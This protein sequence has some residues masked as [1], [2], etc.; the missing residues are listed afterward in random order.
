MDGGA[1]RAAVHG[2]A[3]GRTWLSNFTFTFHFHALEKEMATHSSVRAWRISGTGEPGGAAVYE[4]AQSRTRLKWL[5]SS[6]SIWKDP[7]VGRDWGR[8][9]KG[10]TEWAGWVASPTR[11]TWLWVNSGSWWC[12]GCW[13]SWGRK[14]SDTTEQLNWTELCIPLGLLLSPCFLSISFLRYF[15]DSGTVDHV[16]LSCVLFHSSYP[17]S[18]LFWSLLRGWLLNIDS[19]SAEL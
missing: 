10:T 9:E 8:E 18:C 19:I 1:W 2:V 7:D 17:F 13:G 14:E 3:E 12:L 5:S 15:L 11:W 4:V 6:S 16:I